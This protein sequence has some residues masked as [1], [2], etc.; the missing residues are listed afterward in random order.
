MQFMMVLFKVAKSM[1]IHK[2]LITT[3]PGQSGDQHRITE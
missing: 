2:S 1:S 3:L